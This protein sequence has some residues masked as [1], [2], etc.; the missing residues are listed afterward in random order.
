[1]SSSIT[2]LSSNLTPPQSE[3]SSASEQLASSLTPLD[4]SVIASLFDYDQ[5]STENRSSKVSTPALDAQSTN[6]D[7]TIQPDQ[8]IPG[9]T[10]EAL[11]PDNDRLYQTQSHQAI[12]T[13]TEQEEAEMENDQERQNTPVFEPQ[14]LILNQQP[15]R[16]L[17]GNQ[18][19]VPG[20]Q[21]QGDLNQI[22]DHS[23][24]QEQQGQAN[25]P[26]WQVQ[27]PHSLPPPV[28]DHLVN[29][30]DLGIMDYYGANIQWWRVF[31]LGNNDP[32]AL[33]TCHSA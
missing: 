10:N 4:L 6:S 22:Q 3:S 9:N 18:F 8:F 21:H 15:I 32:V 23:G 20:Y 29:V 24:N 17:P 14:S 19:P 5:D 30:W 12:Q 1:S 33:M 2:P 31:P 25:Q 28:D 13:N 16:A 11:Q 27:N 7:E 26:Q